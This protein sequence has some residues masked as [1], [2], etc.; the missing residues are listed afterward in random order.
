MRM[1]FDDFKEIQETTQ[2]T[3]DD[4][5]SMD[6]YAAS[7][8]IKK[9]NSVTNKKENIKISQDINFSEDIEIADIMLTVKN[10]IESY[11]PHLSVSKIL[12]NKSDKTLELLT[13][14]SGK[15]VDKSLND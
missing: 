9:Y 11:F 6:L 14:I 4:I 13:Q 12:Q 8:G 10:Y 1:F 7:T 3:V 15:S 5:L 2:S